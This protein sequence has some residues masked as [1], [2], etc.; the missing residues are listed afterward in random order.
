ME[1]IVVLIAIIPLIML[2]LLISN[3][4]RLSSLSKDLNAIKNELRRKSAAGVDVK[5]RN[6]QPGVR[7]EK[8]KSG[9]EVKPAAPAPSPLPKPAAK[10]SPPP[11]A[12][13]RT[14]PQP[15]RQNTS[16]P[17]PKRKA[18]YDRILEKNL[19]YE[20]FIG[21][22]LMNKIGIAVL[23]IGIGFFLKLAIDREY[24]DEVGRVLVGF[25]AG[26]VLLFF[27][28]RI[29]ESYRAFSSVLMGGAI[30]VFYFTS[31][32]AYHEYKLIEQVPTFIIMVGIT[33]MAVSFSLLFNRKELAVLSLIGGFATPFLASSGSGNYV[34]LFSYLLILNVGML[35]IAEFRK[36]NVLNVLSLI[37]TWGIFALWV[38]GDYSQILIH[39]IGSAMMFAS[40]FFLVFFAMNMRYHLKHDE[41]PDP[42][43][44]GLILS[45]TGA[46]YGLGVSVLAFADIKLQGLFTALIG[47][48]FLTSL[49]VFQ[50]KNAVHKNI[51]YL[52]IGLVLTFI[53]L[54]A[55]VQLDGNHITLFWA[56]EAV[57][58][59]WMAH[60]SG[61]RI[62]L[63]SGLMVV[64]LLIVSWMMDIAD[65]YTSY[66]IPDL[67][68]IVNK[69]FLTS[70]V[71]VASLYLCSRVSTNL[72]P[73]QL[74]GAFNTKSLLTVLKVLTLST[75]FI[76]GLAE[77]SY[78]VASYFPDPSAWL[79]AI[80][81]TLV[82]LLFIERFFRKSTGGI[83]YLLAGAFA[84]FLVMVTVGGYETGISAVRAFV[85][86][87]NPPLFFHIAMA[88]ASSFV[89]HRA[90][91][92]ARELFRSNKKQWQVYLWAMCTYVVVFAS[93]Q[94][95]IFMLSIFTEPNEYWTHRL[96]ELRKVGY[97][98]L[99]G[100]GS[101]LFMFHGMRQ[102]LR[103][104]RIIA[105]VFFAITIL[106]LFL[107][108]IQ[109]ASEAGRA[110]AFVLLG[111][112]LLVV[113]FMYQKLKGLIIDGATDIEKNEKND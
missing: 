33:A 108:D 72:K 83:R 81:Y 15:I 102:N 109:A 30:T 96:V 90:T 60:K 8:P 44:L 36:W 76:M 47:L 41:A 93:Q 110:V 18:W 75:V 37:A 49:Y 46:F 71:V 6:N 56:A 98:I 107:H 25:L 84:V 19:D 20:K 77:L 52:L 32:F 86:G 73:Q 58:I 54:V 104:V 112:L 78:Q 11:E 70:L 55:P 7:Q 101:F 64:G 61:L 92:L 51:F 65:V 26:G 88:L 38:F 63:R 67:R 3:A 113:S 34:V 94:L 22:N 105:L 39:P 10:P 42:L 12:I 48:F 45:N 23:V 69:G 13:R 53:S 103:T 87:A 95:D 4:M 16:R 5:K 59:F 21:E 100:I 28:H 1:G 24:I 111:A 50:R 29:R 43:R 80:T 99:W 9:E 82:F 66:G 106:K 89:I 40:A 31:W 27:A 14:P 17:K 68:P 79:A 2:V 97:P 35:I 62:L 74:L 91:V 85:E 57:L